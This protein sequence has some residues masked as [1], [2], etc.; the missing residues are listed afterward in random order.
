MT[1]HCPLCNGNRAQPSWLDRVFFE[2]HE[3]Q[4]RECLA[5]RSLYCDPMPD[6]VALSRMYGPDYSMGVSNGREAIRS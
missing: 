6:A 5:C 1:L 2:G 3:F 4:Y